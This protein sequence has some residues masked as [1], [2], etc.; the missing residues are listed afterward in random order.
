MKKTK[1]EDIPIVLCGPAGQR[2]RRCDPFERD[3]SRHRCPPFENKPNVY[4]NTD[5]PLIVRCPE[6]N[7]L[8]KFM[9]QL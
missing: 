8:Q 9:N 4:R 1:L 3:C 6:L 7:Q 2:N 5:E